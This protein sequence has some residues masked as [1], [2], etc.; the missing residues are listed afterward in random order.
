MVHLGTQCRYPAQ[1]LAQKNLNGT[2]G[3]T[4]SDISLEAMQVPSCILALYNKIADSTVSLSLKDMLKAL[5][6][7]SL[8]STKEAVHCS[9]VS[10]SQAAHN[11]SPRQSNSKSGSLT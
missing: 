7:S 10:G 2:F 9:E 5:V 8:S 11:S 6:K 1:T 3:Q 4:P